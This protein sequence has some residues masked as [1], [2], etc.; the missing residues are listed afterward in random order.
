MREAVVLAREDRP[1]DRRLVA[2]VT[3]AGAASPIEDELRSRLRAELPDYMVPS[4][5]VLLDALPLS[6]NGKVD[7]RV[8]PA[9]DDGA[10]PPGHDYVAPG[11]AME[12]RVSDVWATVLGKAHI[13]VE[14]NFFDVGGDSLLLLR[15]VARARHSGVEIT[16]L[17][18]FRFPTVRALAAHLTE[19][20]GDSPDYQHVHARAQQQRKAMAR[21]RRIPRRG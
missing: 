12:K 20:A 17:D 10:R 13:G 16:P 8:L 19:G 14:D 15:V 18:M 5:I 11:T 9:P 3:A 1:G 6:P 2:Y 7:R 4:A 21:E